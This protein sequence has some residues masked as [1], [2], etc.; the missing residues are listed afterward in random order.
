MSYHTK[1]HIFKVNNV[2]PQI[3]SLPAKTPTIY[4]ALITRYFFKIIHNLE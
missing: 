2:K 4:V 3:Q 1:K